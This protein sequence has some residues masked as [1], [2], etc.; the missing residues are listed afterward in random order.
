MTVSDRDEENLRKN[1]SIEEELTQRKRDIKKLQNLIT[2]KDE[3][4]K[5]LGREKKKYEIIFENTC[6]EDEGMMVSKFVQTDKEIGKYIDEREPQEFRDFGS[7]EAY[8]SL[9]ED[10][11]ERIAERAKSFK[12]NLG[13]MGLDRYYEGNGVT[14]RNE[15]EVFQ[16]IRTSFNPKKIESPTGIRRHGRFE[17]VESHLN[18]IRYKEYTIP[19]SRKDNLKIRHPI[20]PIH[21]S[22]GIFRLRSVHSEEEYQST[23]A[24]EAV[25][26][27]DFENVD[28]TAFKNVK[29]KLSNCSVQTVPIETVNVFVQTT[30]TSKENLQSL[31]GTGVKV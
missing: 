17:P 31:A 28:I 13:S 29:S 14:V 19:F 26:Y 11:I 1:H 30:I 6:K 5:K 4:I 23:P 15:K 18:S 20:T 27:F 8:W 21:S 10:R 9:K 3:E 16:N 12:F 24:N 22:E 7:P 25:L 2:E